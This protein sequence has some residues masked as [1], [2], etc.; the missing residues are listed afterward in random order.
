M[1]T[2]TLVTIILLAAL[3]R[4]L[5]HPFN[6]TAVTAIGLFG[7]AY[8]SKEKHWAFII[9]FAAM[10]VSDICL[11]AMTGFGF[12]KGMWVTYLSFALVIAFGFFALR[13][14]NTLNIILGSLG[15]SLIF[16]LITNFAFLYPEAPIANPALGHYPHNFS[17]II[18]SY[19]AGLPFFRNAIVGDLFYSG[20]L[21]GSFAL[22]QKFYKPLQ[23]A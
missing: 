6:F 20:I 1:R 9:P 19:S 8:F 2:S 12:Y 15:G 13:K 16:F 10:L 7:A 5:P 22:I 17:G 3:T 11:E 4:L 14:V 21:F 23:T 18:A